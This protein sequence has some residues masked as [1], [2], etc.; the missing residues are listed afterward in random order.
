MLI[1]SWHRFKGLDADAVVIIEM[2]IRDGARE[3]VNRHVAQSRTKDL[4][5]AIND[6]DR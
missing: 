3:R 6:F 4:L 5:A 2:P 1:A